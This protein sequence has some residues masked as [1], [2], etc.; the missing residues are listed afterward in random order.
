MNKITNDEENNVKYVHLPVLG[1]KKLP[2][3]H[4]SPPKRLTMP[5]FTFEIIEEL[6][7]E[8]HHSDEDSGNSSIDIQESPTRVANDEYSIQSTTDQCLC[9]EEPLSVNAQI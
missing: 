7:Q 2:F 3:S 8:A 6:H 1:S 9:K 5:V 4:A